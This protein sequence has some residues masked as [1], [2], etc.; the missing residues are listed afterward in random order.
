MVGPTNLWIGLGYPELDI[1]VIFQGI[2]IY[3][4]QE[5]QTNF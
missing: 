5:Q 2:N 4:E 1:F 3:N